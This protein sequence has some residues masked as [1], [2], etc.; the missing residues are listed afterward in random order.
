MRKFTTM[1]MT[2]AGVAAMSL[3]AVGVASASETVQSQSIPGKV[4][5][6]TTTHTMPYLAADKVST[7]YP[8]SPVE[9]RCWVEGQMV[10]G[11]D[12]WLMLGG[13]LDFAPRVAIE[14]SASV[15][16]CLP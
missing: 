1:L 16:A 4:I 10:H 14:P 5:S 9:I 11:S 12:I 13:G 7:L 3:A 2:G 6:T 15:P 8:N